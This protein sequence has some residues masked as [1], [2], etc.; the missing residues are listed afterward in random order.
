VPGWRLWTKQ[1]L[2][3]VAGVQ[4]AGRAYPTLDDVN[5]PRTPGTL[6]E[7]R[8]LVTLTGSEGEG[9]TWN[10]RILTGNGEDAVIGGQGSDCID[11][12]D[13]GPHNAVDDALSGDDARTLS[14]N[15]A[16]GVKMVAEPRGAP[17]VPNDLDANDIIKGGEDG[18]V[19]V[20]GDGADSLRGQDGDDVMTGD[21]AR[22]ILFKGEVIGLDGDEDPC[23]GES[24]FNPLDILGLQLLAPTVGGEDI[25]E[26]GRGDDWAFGQYA[27]DTYR[28]WGGRLGH[29]RLVEAGDPSKGCCHDCGGKI[30]VV[31]VTTCSMA[32]SL[33]QDSSSGTIAPR[34]SSAAP[35]T[36]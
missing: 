16:S 15:F 21:N 4:I 26:G 33:S 12:R 20:G 13:R 3:T 1:I 8:E 7:L 36:I 23:D 35:A 27:D 14:V 17:G 19:L 31:K 32:G 6:G 34:S 5:I 11:A 2:P 9:F 28:F 24:C 30:E 29:D 25:I 18:D 10:D 22:V